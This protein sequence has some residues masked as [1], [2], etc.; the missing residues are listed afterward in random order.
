MRVR[1][2][3][4]GSNR[5]ILHKIAEPVPSYLKRGG[6]LE[7]IKFLLD[8]FDSNDGMFCPEALYVSARISFRRRQS[9][10]IANRANKGQC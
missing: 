1:S 3:T 7:R 2:A 8:A 4:R 9:I 6:N 5:C 10:L